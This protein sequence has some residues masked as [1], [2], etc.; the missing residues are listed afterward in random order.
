MELINDGTITQLSSVSAIS[1][2]K[3]YLQNQKAL[4][5]S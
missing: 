1:L 3:K 2:A 5:I 4:N